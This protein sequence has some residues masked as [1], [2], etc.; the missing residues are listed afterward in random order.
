MK[1]A[2]VE[3][4]P[5]GGLYQFALQMADAYA[6][7]GHAVELITGPDPEL[8]P[9]QAGVRLRP[10]LPTWHP[11]ADEPAW[12][13]SGPGAVL[14]KARRGVRAGRLVLAWMRLAVLLGR[15]RP[16]V[17]QWAEWRFALDGWWVRRIV[18]RLGRGGR[19]P[20]HADVAHT[21]KPFEEQR[22]SGELYR[23]STPLLRALGS[24]Y[25]AMDVV[26]VL[27]ESARRDLLD[28]FPDLQRVEVI[29][30]GD[31]GIFSTDTAE[32]GRP[33][34]QPERILFFGTLARYKGLD[35]LL[36]AFALV[37]SDR[38]EAEL[39]I[40]GAVAD[41][42]LDDL[43]TA[44][45]RVG[46]VELRAGYVPAGAVAGLVASTRAVVAPYVVANQS[47]VVHLAQTFARP[48]VATDV[49]DLG[50]AVRDE[51]TGLLVPPANARALA[52]ALLR[53]LV[54]GTLADRLGAAGLARS[55]ASA[56]WKTVAEQVLPIYAELLAGRDS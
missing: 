8:L 12:L 18:D 44:V 22:T 1:I 15:S 26:L 53:V 35:L 55:R 3:F 21:P 46:G 27:G 5:S 4:S 29:P 9:R 24:A 6:A 39:V 23:M 33:S 42:D 50:V 40:A 14:R 51:E 17:V 38:P 36:E 25:A 47:G 43:R 16:D 30:H 54:D 11:A 31:E 13:R 52:D 10:V 41:V 37:R 34:D 2:V 45:Q 28:T 32:V 7:E 48:V 19:G 20:V 49:G 56:S